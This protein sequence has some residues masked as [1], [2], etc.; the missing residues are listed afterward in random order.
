LIEGR[1]LASRAHGLKP[2]I[3]RGRR[4]STSERFMIH[5]ISTNGVAE[6]WIANEMRVFNEAGLPVVLHALREPDHLYF[7]SEWVR[8]LHQATRRIYPLPPLACTISVVLAPMLFGGR[9]WGALR[10]ALFGRRENVRARLAGVAH[11]LVACHWARGLRRR[12]EAVRLIHAQM[13]HS[14]ATI[15][16]YGAWLLDSKFSFTGHAVDL[17]RDRVALVDKVERADFL[18]CIS[19]FHMDFYRRLGAR[20]DQL[21]LVYTGTDPTRFTPRP[22]RAQSTD[23]PPHIVSTCRLIPKKGLSHLIEACRILTGRGI[24]LRCTIAGS[25]P[26]ADPLREQIRVSGLEDRVRLTGTAMPQE[27]LP[28]F[29]HT[30][31]LFCLP[32][33][34][35][36]D[37]DMDGLPI[38]LMEAMACEVPVVSTR[39]VGIPDL[40]IDDETGVLV[41]PGDPVALADA[42]QAVLTDPPRATRLAQAGRRH[43]RE[44][45]NVATC[46]EPLIAQFRT[47]LDGRASSAVGSLT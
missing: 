2:S 23:S 4:H 47:Y 38:T 31:D 9:F 1:K 13:A 19:T 30:A 40:V 15:A 42:L 24:A 17:F 36:P 43:V 39:L 25:G 3:H 16:M 28:A 22:P 41:E 7:R 8:S 20:E 21:L 6:T 37:G 29:L 45:F 46:L 44:H 12:R 26:L 5:Y 27:D 35:A 14:S 33:V 34:K 10:N 11:L 18:A 32:C